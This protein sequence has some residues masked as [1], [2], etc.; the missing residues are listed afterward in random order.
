MRADEVLC[1]DDIRTAGIHTDQSFFLCLPLDGIADAVGGEDDDALRYLIQQLQSAFGAVLYGGDAFF[2]QRFFYICVVNEHA[3]HGD[4]T[5]RMIQCTL[6]G[7]GDRTDDS[8]AVSSRTDL[9]DLHITSTPFV[10][11]MA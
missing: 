9:D 4:G 8:F 1:L 7:D 10:P 3:Q 5:I 6:A 2:F 11:I